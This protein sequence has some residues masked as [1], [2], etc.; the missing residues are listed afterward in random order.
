MHR[1]IV[2][3]TFHQDTA[4]STTLNTAATASD[5]SI[6][7]VD[8]AGFTSGN[9]IQISETVAGTGIQEIGLMTITAISA[10]TPGTLTL[11]RPLGNDYTTSAVIMEVIS[12]MAV[13][14]TLASPEA[15]E[16]EAPP[17]TT[18]QLTR[19]LIS[20][21][22][23]SSPTDVTFGDISALANGVAIRATTAAGRTVT[24][25]NWKINGDMKLDMYDVVYT[26]PARAGPGAYGINGR[27][28]FTKSKV[29]AELDGDA[30]PIQKMEILVQDDLS[31]LSS[32]KIRAQGRVFS[33]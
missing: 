11:D 30:S 10:G 19:I 28:T 3:E 9:E 31:S 17:G 16:V 20:I 24:F 18:W 22:S 5:T 8:T 6:S 15:F 23:D 2:N 14:G 27:W 33:P 26:D 13:V 7:V 12:N 1:K 29:V 21:I 25:A 4:T 32:F